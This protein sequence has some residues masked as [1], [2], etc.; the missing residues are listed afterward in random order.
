[1]SKN[2]PGRPAKPNM[3][4]RHISIPEDVDALVRAGMARE[5][6]EYSSQAAVMIRRGAKEELVNALE[7]EENA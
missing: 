7:A 2:N 5:S 4:R 1:M 3:V 6:R